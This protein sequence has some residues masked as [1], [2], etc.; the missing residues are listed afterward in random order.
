MAHGITNSTIHLARRKNLVAVEVKTVHWTDQFLLKNLA[1]GRSW[2]T[3][4]LAADIVHP[5]TRIRDPTEIVGDY[6]RVIRH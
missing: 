2:W 1:S 4:S 3:T 5:A 6:A